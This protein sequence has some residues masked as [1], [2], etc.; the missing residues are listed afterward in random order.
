MGCAR[1][2][3]SRVSPMCRAPLLALVLAAFT[4]VLSPLG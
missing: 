2:E 1:I 3:T 4:L